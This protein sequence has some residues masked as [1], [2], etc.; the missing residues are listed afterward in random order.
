[1]LLLKPFEGRRLKSFLLR[2]IAIL[3]EDCPLKNS[4]EKKHKLKNYSV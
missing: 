4:L 2:E 3:M 1:M